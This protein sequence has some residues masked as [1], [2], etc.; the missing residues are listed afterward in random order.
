MML[1]AIRRS[2]EEVDGFEVVAEASNGSDV[3]P[4]IRSTTPDVVLIDLRMPKMDGLTCLEQI[5]KKHPDVKVIIL[6]ASTDEE[7]INAALT[8]GA[9]AYIVKSV[10]PVD[11]PAVVRQASEGAV[12][13]AVGL[14]QDGDQNVAKSMGLT[15]RELTILRAIAD[16][17][18][19]DGIA[20]K[21]WIA[22]QTVKF[23]LT[24]IY[25]K[26]QVANRT[27]AARFAYS[28]GLVQQP[29]LSDTD[30]GILKPRA[31]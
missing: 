9:S 7:L 13:S 10:N 27:E 12:F 22:E 28:H 24:N 5:R 11:L 29:M 19:N 20:K 15:E 8:R 18:S 30:E 3:L 4:L 21:F 23:H 1:Y 26:L 25:R 14:P 2:L 16:G 6:S 17:M 31:G